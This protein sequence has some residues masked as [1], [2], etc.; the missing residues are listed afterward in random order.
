MN[1]SI[2]SLLIF[3][4]ILGSIAMLVVAKSNTEGKENLYKIRDFLSTYFALY[5][6]ESTRYRM[7]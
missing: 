5:V 7:K 3:L 6:F 2:L 1:S 4:P